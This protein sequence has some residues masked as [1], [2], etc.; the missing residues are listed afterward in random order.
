MDSSSHMTRFDKLAGAS[1]FFDWNFK[2]QLLLMK[3][4][5][6]D[7]ITEENL[8]NEKSDE[9]GEPSFTSSSTPTASGDAAAAGT[10][11]PTSGK[12]RLTKKK[13]QR[14]LA[15]IGL[16]VEDPLLIH[17]RGASSPSETVL[18]R[19]HPLFATM[20]CTL[21]YEYTHEATETKR[22]A[23]AHVFAKG[24]FRIYCMKSAR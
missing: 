23:F 18:T 5:L 6:W 7:R 19:P 17:V 24:T 21:C 10:P 15:L 4:D 20:P 14:T 1:N 8:N 3:E 22:V 9:Q 2:M 12:T 16:S 11:A 13:E